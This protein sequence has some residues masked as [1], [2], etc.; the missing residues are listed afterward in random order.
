MLGRANN[1]TQ[2]NNREDVMS[3][4][5]KKGF[6]NLGRIV[7]IGL[8]TLLMLTNIKLALLDDNEIAS[9]DIS[10]LGIEVN[11]FE[12][13]YACYQQQPGARLFGVDLLVD[14]CY[15]PNWDLD[16]ACDI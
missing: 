10:V 5:T 13:T 15:C 4:Q 1:K 16:C 7:G 6:K 2:T 14:P 11:L 12:A 9:G 3:V 8:F